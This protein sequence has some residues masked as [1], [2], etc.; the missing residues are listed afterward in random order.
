MAFLD[1]MDNTAGANIYNGDIVQVTSFKK[2]LTAY[3][4]VFRPELPLKISVYHLSG[5]ACKF[6]SPKKTNPDS[7]LTTTLSIHNAA[8]LSW[9]W[10]SRNPES[11]AS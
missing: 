3:R 1:N 2:L 10:K 5:V 11:Y 8:S 7:N 9:N 4:N 6:A